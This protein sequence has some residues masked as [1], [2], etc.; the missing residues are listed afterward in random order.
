MPEQHISKMR[1]WILAARPKTLPAA[2]VPVL[3]GSAVAWSSGGFSFW[4]AFVACTCALCIQIATN[5][6]N[7][8]FDFVKGADTEK[9][10][11]PVR[12]VQSG[13][14][15]PAHVRNAMIAVLVITF[16][17]GLYLVAIGGW[18]ILLIGLVSILC[19]VIYTAGPFPLAYLG[20]GDVFVFFFFGIVAVT[21]THFVQT[22][23]W[24]RDALIPSIPIGAIATAI[25]VVNNYRDIDTDREVGKR[26]LAV[27][28]GR[29]ASVTEFRLLL[30]AAYLI[31][32]GQVF[33]GSGHVWLILPLA[34][35]P[36][37]WKLQAI[38]VR[39]TDGTLLNNALGGTGKL[40]ALYGSLYSIGIILS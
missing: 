31:P 8:Y 12:V 15:A 26:T 16:V 22:L 20:L 37:A 6:A 34:S 17:L 33:I 27:R 29:S 32:I 3:V 9:R 10:V 21:G 23:H 18:P 19:A 11:G 14:I 1:S 7:D 2:V 4:P 28:M 36:L 25:L 30:V 5:F 40:L 24:S 38:V 13:L 39:S 35:L